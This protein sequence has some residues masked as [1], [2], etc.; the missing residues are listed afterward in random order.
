MKQAIIHMN[1]RGAPLSYHD[2]RL[3]T[4]G[5]IFFAVPHQGLDTSFVRAIV[6]NQA[7]EDLIN[8]LRPNSPLLLD[9]RRDFNDAFPFRDS[10]IVYVYETKKSPTAQKVEH[11]Q[12]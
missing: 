10:T 12:S 3:A 1:R 6:R 5:I 8:E 11:N 9:M 7:N 4:C 2:T